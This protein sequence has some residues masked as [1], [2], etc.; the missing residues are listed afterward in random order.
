MT[1]VET[2]AIFMDNETNFVTEKHND[3]ADF[4]EKDSAHK[5]MFEPPITHAQKSDMVK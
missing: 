4:L 3:H 2:L 5:A 1:Y